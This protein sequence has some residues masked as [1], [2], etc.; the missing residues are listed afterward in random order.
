[1][2]VN[3][4]AATRFLFEKAALQGGAI[5]ERFYGA[6][7]GGLSSQICS[8]SSSRCGL[9]SV[10]LVE[11]QIHPR[12]TPSRRTSVSMTPSPPPLGD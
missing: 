7:F 4:Q 10:I 9:F 12:G 3:S 11:D 8:P 2:D 6:V 5:I 1:V